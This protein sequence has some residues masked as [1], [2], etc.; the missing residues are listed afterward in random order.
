MPNNDQLA[1]IKNFPLY[2]SENSELK[3]N[4]PDADSGV[5]FETVS[6]SEFIERVKLLGYYHGNTSI[7]GKNY[8]EILIKLED[9][10]PKINEIT[11]HWE[12]C[13]EDTGVTA[14]GETGQ[15]GQ[16][17]QNGADGQDGNDGN[18]IASIVVT[19]GGANDVVPTAS[20]TADPG[21]FSGW[22]NSI[23]SIVTDP[24]AWKYI[25]ICIAITD[26]NGTTTNIIYNCGINGENG[27]TGAAGSSITAITIDTV[28]TTQRRMNFTTSDGSTIN[29][30][31][32]TVPAGPQ[33]N[34][35]ADGKSSSFN[36]VTASA[37]PFNSTPTVVLTETS[38][39]SNIYNL[40]FGIPNGKPGTKFSV[41]KYSTISSGWV[42]ETI[43]NV[44]CKTTTIPLSSL[45]PDPS[46]LP[47]EYT[48]DLDEDVMDFYYDEEDD[49]NTTLGVEN[50]NN[51]INAKFVAVVD[52]TNR[53]SMIK[54][55]SMNP[56][57]F[58]SNITYRFKFKLYFNVLV[59]EEE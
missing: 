19:Y 1:K 39:G 53:P 34:N 43:G 3:L 40:D 11:N 7:H 20:S 28:N 22:Q 25:Y 49:E 29:P 27:A 9:F 41:H 54:L 36:A 44:S 51:C 47:E 46:L 32:F 14:T 38:S 10:I 18:G 24:P 48:F 31:V 12:I 23:D 33:G 45:T 6:I 26:T 5:D 56:T 15:D 42:S 8:P 2:D 30:V 35:G 37:L 55:V 4:T 59:T 58:D 13:G 16:D 57:N 52:S 50:L 17:G 21:H